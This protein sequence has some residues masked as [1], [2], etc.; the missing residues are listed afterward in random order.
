MRYRLRPKLMGHKPF[1][2]FGLVDAARDLIEPQ[3][4]VRLISEHAGHLSG[5]STG[6]GSQPIYV[7]PWCWWIQRRESSAHALQKITIETD[8]IAGCSMRNGVT[9]SSPQAGHVITV[10][11]KSLEKEKSSWHPKVPSEMGSGA[12]VIIRAQVSR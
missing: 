8:W 9:K 10:F 3:G 1:P 11:G 4:A 12:V 5:T 7:W 2:T 6:R